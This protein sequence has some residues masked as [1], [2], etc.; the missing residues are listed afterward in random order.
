MS[1]SNLCWLLVYGGDASQHAYGGDG[2]F[3]C[4]RR[5]GILRGFL[6]FERC[7]SINPFFKSCRPVSLLNAFGRFPFSPFWNAFGWMTPFSE[8]GWTFP[9]SNRLNPFSKHDLTVKTKKRDENGTH[10]DSNCIS[11]GF[12]SLGHQLERQLRGFCFEEF[13]FFLLVSV[14][15]R[16]LSGGGRM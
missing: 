12:P 6:F 7:R 14:R 13:S 5:V 4:N 2:G 3:G 16:H 9:F 8:H 10:R 1:Q 11:A 15:R